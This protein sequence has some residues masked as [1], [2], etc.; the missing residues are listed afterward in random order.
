MLRIEILIRLVHLFLLVTEDSGSVFAASLNTAFTI[1]GYKDTHFR[2]VFLSAFDSMF[3]S[4][5]ASVSKLFKLGNGWSAGIVGA[6]PKLKNISTTD[7]QPGSSASW[8]YTLIFI[9]DA[10]GLAGL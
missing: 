6:L 8:I 3:T 1:N 5:I 9:D 10:C 4:C 2:F 7:L